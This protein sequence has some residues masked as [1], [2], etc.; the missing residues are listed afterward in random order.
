VH[1]C[2]NQSSFLHSCLFAAL[3]LCLILVFNSACSQSK[4]ERAKIRLGYIQSDLH[5]L[6]AFVAME[7]GL[8]QQQGLDVEVAGVFRAGPELMSAFAAQALDVGYVGLAPAIT[9][10]ANNNIPLRLI[11]QVN[12]EGSA[13]VVG[14]TSPC[15]SAAD[16]KGKMIAIPGHAT[17]QDFLLR[18]AVKNAGILVDQVKIIVLKPPEMIPA[19]TGQDIDAF[20]AWEPYP[21]KALTENTGKIVAYS[22]QI[23]PDHPCCVIVAGEKFLQAR[24]SDAEKLKI[25]HNQACRFIQDNRTE[26]IDIGVKYTGMDRRTIETALG[27][28]TY[29]GQLQQQDVSE[30]IEFLKVLRYIKKDI[31]DTLL[32]KM[33]K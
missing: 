10:V 12:T 22:S 23:W 26:A 21:S 8:F 31:S 27:H 28:I 13:I 19:L 30:Y 20:I 29:N 11:A 14:K 1:S 15:T 6:P 2:R 32:A 5:H 3:A 9:A 16:L 33:L 17:M 25:A 24:S 4:N 7:K 18:K